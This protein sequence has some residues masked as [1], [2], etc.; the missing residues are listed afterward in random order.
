MRRTGSENKWEEISGL[1]KKRIWRRGKKR[2]RERSH[3]GP[4]TQPAKSKKERKT[5]RV[6]KSKNP[7]G[8]R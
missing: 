3:Q 6:K 2:R 8:K 1:E 7:W 4:A 5:Y